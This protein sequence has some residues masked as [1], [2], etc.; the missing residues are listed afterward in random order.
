KSERGIV[1]PRRTVAARSEAGPPSELV[2][3]RRRRLQRGGERFDDGRL[4]RLAVAALELGDV[5]VMHTGSSSK[6][7]HRQTAL[8]PELVQVAAKP[9]ARAQRQ[10]HA[11]RPGARRRLPWSLRLRGSRLT[12]GRQA[13]LGGRSRWP[14]RAIR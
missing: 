5:G 4:R 1:L 9:A 7:A 11:A 10:G 2:K 14:L 8:A 13:G 12:G 3:L 6:R